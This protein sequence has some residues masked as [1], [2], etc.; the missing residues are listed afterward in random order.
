M[1]PS[2][3]SNWAMA[4]PYH[5][6]GP[7][8]HK[9]QAAPAAEDETGAGSVGFGPRSLWIGGLLDWMDENYLYSCF[10]R[11]PELL[12]VVIKRNKETR[13][14]EGFGFL[15]FADHVTADQILHSY[16]GQRMPNA[17]RDFR[18]NWVMRTAPEK[19][20]SAKPAEDDHAIY[21]GGLAYDVTDF[22]LHNV[23]KNRYPSVTRATVIRDGFV[24]PSKGYGFVLFGDVS[25]R[26]QAM[27]EMDGA[28]CSTR[29]MHIRAATGSRKQGTDSDGNWDNKRLFVRGLDLSVTAEDLKKAFSPYGEITNTRIIEGK[30]CGFITYT[31][32]ASAEEALRI[33]DG[34]QLGDNTMR[35]FWARPLSNKKLFVGGLDLSVTAEDLKKA[36]SPYGEITDTDV[37]LVEGKC[38]G[39]VA[40]SS[41]ASAEEA[42]RILNGSQLGNNTMRIFWARRLSNKKDEANDEYHGH[43]QGSGPDYGCSPGDSNMHGYKGRGGYA[44]HQQKQPQQTPVQ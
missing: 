43:P 19:P 16:N 5:Y 39:F 35:I 13:Q 1:A 14:S 9:E 20:A 34:S 44:Y 27:T 26:R 41:R 37:T 36:F 21:V 8:P 22:M 32:R 24:G 4:P 7:P 33:L 18:L 10:T 12:S 15:N 25:E 3:S 42:R 31:S 23:F 40:Y 28:Y 11:S 6:H 29:P 2:P 38:C 30:C 17:D